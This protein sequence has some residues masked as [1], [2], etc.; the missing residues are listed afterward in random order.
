MPSSSKKTT[1][2]TN[3][4][5]GSCKG[6]AYDGNESPLAIP[7]M[8]KANS[9]TATITP[10][11]VKGHAELDSKPFH[12]AQI[13]ADFTNLYTQPLNNQ[14]RRSNQMA[15]NDNH[16]AAPGT[17]TPTPTSSTSRTTQLQA[18]IPEHYRTLRDLFCTR[19]HHTQRF[20][21]TQHASTT[22]PRST[23]PNPQTPNSSAAP[24]TARHPHEA[25]EDIDLRSPTDDTDYDFIS[26][27]EAPHSSRNAQPDHASKYA[28]NHSKRSSSPSSSSSVR[29]GIEDSDSGEESDGE[30][31][32]WRSY[33]FVKQSEAKFSARNASSDPAGKYPELGGGG[34]GNKN[35]EKW[36]SRG[37]VKGWFS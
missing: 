6:K 13:H 17:S 21:E 24:T 34:G 22:E 18:S 7:S 3:R 25:L 2:K 37:W 35:G 27:A 12:H 36:G 1:I 8:E 26:P 32:S 28:A 14:T 33:D 19:S 11:E 10:H 31:T 20:S 9:S 5:T 30:S 23:T 16:T 29:R 4:A 15:R